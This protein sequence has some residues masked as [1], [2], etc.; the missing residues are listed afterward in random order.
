MCLRKTGQYS[1]IFDCAFKAYKEGGLRVFYRG[2]VPNILGILPY[3]GIDLALYE[4]FKRGYL[5]YRGK[6]GQVSCMK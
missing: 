6:D 2:Y 1:S 4:T 3:A 5:S